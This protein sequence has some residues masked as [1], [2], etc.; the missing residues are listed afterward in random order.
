[1]SKERALSAPTVLGGMVFFTSFAPDADICT[2][3]GEG[4][5]Y[6]LF[7][8]TGS[9]YKEAVIGTYASGSNTNSTR[10]M[11]LGTGLPSQMAVQI[12]AQGSGNSGSASGSGCAGRVTGFIQASTGAL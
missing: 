5:I 11:A 7:Y 2:A 4:A 1:M 9:A 10:S 6:A 8:K 3:S 12:G